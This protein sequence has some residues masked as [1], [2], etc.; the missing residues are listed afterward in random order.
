MSERACVV[1]DEANMRWV[2]NEVLSSMGYE[3]VTTSNGQEAL[4][5]VAEAAP[6]LV[7]LDLKLKGMDGLT[8]LR[9]LRERWPETVVL[10][11]TAY[12]TVA[13]AVEAMQLGAADYLRKPFNVEE[14]TF[15]I[16][17]ALERK[18]LQSE[19]RQ[20]RQA[21][22]TSAGKETI[23][24]H[25]LWVTALEQVRSLTA[26]DLD[27]LFLGEAGVGK[28]HLAR[29]SYALSARRE[30]PLI[31]VD[32]RT[33]P[34]AMQKE[35]LDGQE[36]WEGIWSQA[37]TGTVLLRHSDTLSAEGWK[38][39]QR[40][41][42]HGQKRPK[43]RLLLTGHHLPPAMVS[44]LFMTQVQVPALRERVEDLPLFV[45]ACAPVI[46]LTPQA[47]ML[48]ERYNWPGNIAELRGVIERV[49][50]LAGGKPIEERHLP[51]QI[52]QAPAP[53]TRIRLPLEGLN[54]EEVEVELIR[55]ALEQAGGNKTRAADLLG[56]S[57]HTL[58]YRLEKYGL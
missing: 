18:A 4:S 19:V 9:K 39:V 52:R 33:L 45:R 8:V 2:L 21:M 1:D 3:V 55:Q 56:L 23:G 11:L 40:M 46:E 54:L 27:I 13:T 57:R 31:E 32:L 49:A 24:S 44:T 15:K 50:A 28:T 47:L 53:G 38:V 30:A 35:V 48:L 29:W 20:L 51:E 7:I 58:L 12:G 6:Q 22:R 36:G 41:V 34:G 26:L 10:I 43:P 16:Q 5:Q 17:R 42:A 37:G 14:I 25:P